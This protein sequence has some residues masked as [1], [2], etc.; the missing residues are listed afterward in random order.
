MGTSMSSA[1]S[2]CTVTH[3]HIRPC[4]SAVRL[5]PAEAAVHTFC[6]TADPRHTMMLVMA[7]SH[8]KSGATHAT[9]RRALNRLQDSLADTSRHAVL[10]HLLREFDLHLL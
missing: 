6:T 2:P 5:P 4:G 7:S 8:V 1:K 3:P 10:N 9:R